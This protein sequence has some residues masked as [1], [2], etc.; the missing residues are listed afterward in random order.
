MALI[1]SQRKEKKMRKTKNLLFLILHRLEKP[2]ME[3]QRLG[4]PYKTYLQRG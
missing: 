4:D 3:S 1:D 2:I